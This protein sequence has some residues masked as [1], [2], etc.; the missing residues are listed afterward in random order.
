[1]RWLCTVTTFAISINNS[2][3][4]PQRH[5]RLSHRLVPHV[6]RDKIVDDPMRHRSSQRPQ[7]VHVMVL[8]LILRDHQTHAPRW[9]ESYQNVNIHR[10]LLTLIANS[11]HSQTPVYPGFAAEDANVAKPRVTPTSI[12]LNAGP[13][14]LPWRG[15]RPTPKAR[16]IK[17]RPN[18][19]SSTNNCPGEICVAS[20]VQ[21]GMAPCYG[22][23]KTSLD[24]MESC[25]LCRL[26]PSLLTTGK[27]SFPNP[28]FNQYPPTIAPK[29]CAT[30]YST[31]LGSVLSP[32]KNV[33]IVMLGLMCP[34]DA[35]D[36]AKM[37]KDNPAV[38]S[39]AAYKLIAMG[40][41]RRVVRPEAP[42]PRAK[43]RRQVIIPS[44]VAIFQLSR[45][46]NPEGCRASW[47]V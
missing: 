31:L 25:A 37:N 40:D 5:R 43:T 35:G 26:T 22:F 42:A 44:T 3:R 29:V 46:R 15:S 17:P 7:P 41:T 27:Y 20:T 23:S 1:M 39:S 19:Y 21:P 13:S 24:P 36:A 4:A 11:L 2:S 45:T 10:L 32:A 28:N 30:I 14:V 16:K 9:I 38:F 6:R 47:R 33:A 34:P 12:G 8:H 18:M